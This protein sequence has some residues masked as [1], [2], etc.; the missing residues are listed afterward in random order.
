MSLYLAAHTL[1][2]ILAN[3]FWL[4]VALGK[5]AN[6]LKD[7][8]VAGFKQ[9]LFGEYLP[10]NYLLKTRYSLREPTPSVY[11]K[12]APLLPDGFFRDKQAYSPRGF[13][14]KPRILVI[15]SGAMGDVLLAT[16]IIRK[17][18]QDR[19]GYCEIDVVTRY[20][21]VFAN[22]PYVRAVLTRKL[23]KKQR[24]AYDLIINLDMVLERNKAVHV[25]DSYALYAHGVTDYDKQPELFP[26]EGDSAQVRA[27]TSGFV[28]GYIVAHNRRDPTQ[29]YRNV[30]ET[31]WKQ[32]LEDLSV[33]GLPILQVGLPGLDIALQGAGLMDFR[34]RL[35]LQ[36][37]QLLIAD[38]RLFVGTDAGPL[39][40]AAT[41]ST[42]IVSFF[43]LAH[44][45]ARK[46]LRA[47]MDERFIPITP[48]LDCYGCNQDN[49]LPWGGFSCRRGDNACSGAFSMDKAR[50]ACVHLGKLLDSL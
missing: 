5:M 24:R 19:E 49:P 43:T 40:V 33:Y 29:A 36:Q 2:R 6:L 37:L 12:V 4:P 13:T 44:H 18:H 39:H 15:R 21:E 38:A 3:P 28:Q 7:T 47:S 41:T 10:R 11:E 1:L 9:Y 25:T 8:G 48:E 27:L 35:S 46:P 34:N 42:P 45:D 32:L 23:L 30:D 16:P 22:S 26:G 20:P 17:L 31:L 14:C 50:A